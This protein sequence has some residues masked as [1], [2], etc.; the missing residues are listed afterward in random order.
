MP[1]VDA[2][3]LIRLMASNFA[4]NV[5]IKRFQTGYQVQY[6]NQMSLSLPPPLNDSLGLPKTGL[7]GGM[8]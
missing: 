6:I 3:A 8:V 7:D 2:V 1:K 5:G 4:E